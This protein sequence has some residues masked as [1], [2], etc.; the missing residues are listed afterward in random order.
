MVQRWGFPPSEPFTFPSAGAPY[1]NLEW[2]F[3]VILY[4][5]Y[6]AGGFAGVILLKAA[7]IALVFLIIWKDAGL[8]AGRGAGDALDALIRTAVLLPLLLMVKHR[9]VERPDLVLMLFLSFTIYALNTYLSQ[10]RC[11][12]LYVLP[13]VQVLWVNMHPSIVAGAVPFVALL[14]GGVLL[15]GLGRWRGAEIPEAP[16]GRQLTTIALVFAA[17]LVA[18]LLNPHGAEPLMV[19][20]RLATSSW[21]ALHILELQ[22]PRPASQP[23][24]FVVTALLGATLLASARR[25]PVIPALLVAP[26]ISLGLSA[27]RF[28]PILIIVAAPVLVRNIRVM[29]GG[30]RSA[31]GRRA[32]LTLASTAT[33]L[34]LTAVGL[35]VGTRIEPFADGRKIP[36]FGVNDLFLPEG[37]LRYLDRIGVQGRVLNKLHWGGY[38]AW[39][40][41]PRRLAIV[42]GRAYLPPGLLGA[43]DLALTNPELL[44]R[45]QGEHG[46]DVVLMAYPL[47][48]SDASGLDALPSPSRWALVYWDDVALVYLRRSAGLAGIIGRDEYRQVKPAYGV[49]YLRQALAG[50]SALR[51]LMAESGRN[52][53]ETGSSI[54]YTFLGF[55][56]LQAGDLDQAIETFG[57]VR[58]YSTVWDAQ[59]GLAL[60]YWQ[61]GDLPQAI[62]RYRDL[63]RGSD[64]PLITFNLGLA[65]AKSGQDREA[66]S[67]LERARANAPWLAAVYPVLIGAYRRLGEG[68]REQELQTA[69]AAARTRARAAQHAGNAA[70][71]ER[72]GRL[73]E[74]VAELRSALS[75]DSRNPEVLSALG[76]VYLRQNRLD[77]ARAQHD[78][79]LGIDPGLARA[80]YGLALV[81]RRRGER[82]DARR[83]LEEYVRLEPRSY[84]AWQARQELGQSEP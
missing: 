58:G 37:A 44:D 42:D 73:A 16:A 14:G 19:P 49:G 30:V 64:D 46:F 1:Y 59:Q 36:G 71:L 5:A 84:L 3:D 39:R 7:L 78:A 11:R 32:G 35:T 43:I 69:S 82:A 74:A 20:F 57:R 6:L 65:L 34:A 81:H 53:A 33:A 40:D 56:L 72:Q 54:G 75:L 21:H 76:D 77:E 13:L 68:H 31:W 12:Y 17:V 67:H 22:P 48:A 10:G 63:L 50:P 29:A 66:V 15:R 38:I 61:K 24:P 55:A 60:A 62:E 4:L 23:G 52:V 2:L 8:T 25:Y 80:H 9:I 70:R 51:A 47:I 27:L 83:H 28:I 18:S 41:H 45:L 26:F 79:A